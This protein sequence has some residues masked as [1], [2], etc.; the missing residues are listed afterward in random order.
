MIKIK[1]ARSLAPEGS[2]IMVAMADSNRE[3]IDAMPRLLPN[4]ALAR[5]K[6]RAL[7]PPPPES[8]RARRSSR[9]PCSIPTFR[10]EG[11]SSCLPVL[12]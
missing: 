9:L 8:S 4:A 7:L 1:A 5:L 10:P 2:C 6:P 3:G 11:F 12:C